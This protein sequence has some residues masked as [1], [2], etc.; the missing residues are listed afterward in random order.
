MVLL[1]PLFMSLSLM[2]VQKVTESGRMRD[3]TGDITLTN[4]SPLQKVLK[5][6]CFSWLKGNNTALSSLSFNFAPL[7]KPVPNKHKS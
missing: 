1:L 4:I 6:D 2:V 7:F 5:L 3:N